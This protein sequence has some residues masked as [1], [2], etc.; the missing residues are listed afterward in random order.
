MVE[1]LE[2]AVAG[3]DVPE[4]DKPGLNETIVGLRAII[5]HKRSLSVLNE[6]P[7]PLAVP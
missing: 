1:I 4:A 5:E 7:D 3:S 2:A 6:T